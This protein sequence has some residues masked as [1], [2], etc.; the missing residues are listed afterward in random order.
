M[1]LLN[2]RS[3]LQA[4]AGAPALL[5][6]RS[7]AADVGRGRVALIRHKGLS[8]LAGRELAQAYAGMLEE[9]FSVLGVDL[10]GQGLA[11]RKT[12]S[13]K[14]NCLAGRPL[15][16]RPE[17]AFQVAEMLRSWGAKRVTLWERSW[18]ELLGAGYRP[19]ASKAVQLTATDRPDV[20]YSRALYESG[21][22]G[23]LVSN[24]L[25]QS[26]AMVSLGVMKDHDLAGITCALKNLYG[27][28]HNPNKYHDNGCDPFVA[29]VAA[30]KPIR[31]RVFL[32]ILD[33]AVAQCHGGPAYRASW[34]WE[35]DCILVSFDLVAADRVALD[36]IEAQRARQGLE[37]LRKAGRYPAWISTAAKMGL[38]VGDLEQIQLLE[39]E[40]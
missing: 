16:P 33:G 12:V 5:H 11:G 38:G 19:G 1:W 24:A 26:E 34:A 39:R 32:T 35:L 20:G 18:R 22:V 15:S 31:E 3:F 28:I 7:T 4:L 8:Q 40:I 36:I 27:V 37:T 17:L 9:A 23:S 10:A 2:R 30:M 6:C 25:L 13:L 21:D 29:Q 14:A